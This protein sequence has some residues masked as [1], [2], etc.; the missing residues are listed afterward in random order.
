MEDLSR[1]KARIVGRVQ[2]V[3]F[4]V[5][6]RHQ[7]RQRR[8]TGWVRNCPDGSVE[9]VAE[10]SRTACESLRRWCEQGPPGARVDQLEVAWEEPTSEFD[11]F[12]VRY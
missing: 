7:A 8:L 5:S 12:E 2:G 9:L 10:G 11:G 3:F 6:T 4:R 1:L